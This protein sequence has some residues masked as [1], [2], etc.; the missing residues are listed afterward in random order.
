[1]PSRW[2]SFTISRQSRH[3]DLTVRTKRSANAFAF[4][5]PK[6]SPED[7]G[8]LGV[9][10]SIETL[11]IFEQNGVDVE[12]VRGHEAGRLRTQELTPGGAAPA[13]EQG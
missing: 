3:S 13:R 11:H 7:L 4:G 2:T 12:E 8:T 1:M 9:Q 5:T 10:H 6:G